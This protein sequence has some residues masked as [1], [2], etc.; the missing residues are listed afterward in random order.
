[1]GECVGKGLIKRVRDRALK[2]TGIFFIVVYARILHLYLRVMALSKLPAALYEYICTYASSLLSFLQK[3][4]DEN[5]CSLLLDS[6]NP[7]SADHTQRITIPPS[8]NSST[9]T[10]IPHYRRQYPQAHL[11]SD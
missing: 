11:H 1:M 7:L 6:S 9:G 4:R 3:A 5:R 8:P 10:R 2:E